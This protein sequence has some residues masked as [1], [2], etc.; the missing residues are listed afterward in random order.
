MPSD[1]RDNTEEMPWSEPTQLGPRPIRGDAP[2]EYVSTPVAVRGDPLGKV[3]WRGRQWAVTVDGI[4]KLDGT[5]FI[6]RNWL[7]DGLPVDERSWPQH[8]SGKAWVDIDDFVTA[9]LVAI[10]LHWHRDREKIR[11]AVAMSAP[12][13]NVVPL[14]VL[15][16]T[17]EDLIRAAS[18]DYDFGTP[19]ALAE[20]IES[21]ASV[22]ITGRIVG[23]HQ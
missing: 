14:P 11:R 3:L 22:L 21:L 8:V 16:K 10:S 20:K 23:P 17:I 1:A 15:K 6:G 13:H 2:V 4:E 9:W 5:Y 12:P 7:F 19:E 18:S